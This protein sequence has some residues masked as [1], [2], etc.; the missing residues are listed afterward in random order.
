ML[1]AHLMLTPAGPDPSRGARVARTSYLDGLIVGPTR[2]TATMAGREL[3][4]FG[5]NRPTSPFPGWTPWWE[6]PV[7]SGKKPKRKGCG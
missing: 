2:H 3:S 1:A 5:G 7:R 6:S 4:N